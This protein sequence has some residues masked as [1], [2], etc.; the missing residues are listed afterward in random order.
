MLEQQPVKS[1]ANSFRKL[2]QLIREYIDRVQPPDSL[3]LVVTALFVGVGTGLG[4][5]VFVWALREVGTFVT[6]L[7]N[8]IGDI[9]GLLVAMGLAG[10]LV[11]YMLDRWA[12]SIKVRTAASV[13]Y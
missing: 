13:R 7:Q 12:N 8:E 10:L 5:V 9:I 3:V 2:Q 4:A 11:G 1:E 6:W